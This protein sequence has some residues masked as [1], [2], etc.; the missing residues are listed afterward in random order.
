LSTDLDSV[1]W[2]SQAEAAR[3]R[4]VSRQAIAALV[5]K[6]RFRTLKIGGKVLVHRQDVEAFEPQQPGPQPK[7]GRSRKKIAS[8]K[9]TKRAKANKK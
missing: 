7:S 3:L 5:K 2:I 8:K 4:S 9:P 1:L 6:G